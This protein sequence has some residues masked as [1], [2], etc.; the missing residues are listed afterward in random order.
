MLKLYG[1]IFKLKNKFSNAFDKLAVIV[2]ERLKKNRQKKK[3]P[4]L[5]IVP[6]DETE[7]GE[8]LKTIDELKIIKELRMI[9]EMRRVEHIDSIQALYSFQGDTP[10]GIVQINNKKGGKGQTNIHTQDDANVNIKSK[11]TEMVEISSSPSSKQKPTEVRVEEE[12]Q[13]HPNMVIEY[14]IQET[15]TDL[16][17]ETELD[18]EAEQYTETNSQPSSPTKLN[19]TSSNNVEMSNPN[20]SQV[21]AP[22]PVNIRQPQPI[23]NNP[24]ML[25]QSNI[26][27][28]RGMARMGI[29]IMR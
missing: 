5:R 16:V 9:E 13:E 21:P 18:T 12:I 7:M 8:E 14:N 29:K 24:M 15:E 25:R 1:I 22:I 27:G 28:R 26:R 2:K 11:S 10:V 19:D 4:N 3:K 6:I 20:P 23:I 17:T